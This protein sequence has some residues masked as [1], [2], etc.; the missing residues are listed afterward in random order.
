MLTPQLNGIA[1]DV[2]NRDYMKIQ[3]MKGLFVT[4]MEMM[5]I[6]SS[7]VQVFP[8]TPIKRVPCVPDGVGNEEGDLAAVLRD[9]SDLGHLHPVAELGLLIGI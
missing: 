8:T 2:Q 4:G 3:L 6:C 9:L 1:S 7:E 5:M